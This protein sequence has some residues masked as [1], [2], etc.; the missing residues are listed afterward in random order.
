MVRVLSIGSDLDYADH[1]D[2]DEPANVR[3]YDI[4]F[5]NLRDLESRKDEFLH[6]RV[7]A[8]Y[9]RQ[10]EFPDPEHIVQQLV[11]GGDIFILL[12]YALQAQPS[13]DQDWAPPE[14]IPDDTPIPGGTPVLNFLSWLPFELEVHDDGGESVAE[15]TIDEDWGWYFPDEFSWNY[16]IPKQGARVDHVAFKVEPLVENRYGECLGARI[17]VNR[18]RGPRSVGLEP[19]WGTIYLLP[20]MDGWGIEHLAYNVMEYLYPDVDIETVGRQPD[21]LATYD[22]PR[23]RELEQSIN[24]LEEELA[25][26]RSVK[27]LLWEED[28]ELQEAVYDAL[29]KAGVSIQEEVDSR[30]DGAIDLG[31]QMVMLE[32]TGTTGGVS[33]RKI[34]QLQKWVT[35]NEKGYGED[36]GG[37]LVYN[38]DR[39]NDPAD[40]NLN[41]DPE[42][43]G[44]LEESGLQLVT[45]LELFKMVLGIEAGDVEEIDVEE[46][47]RSDES[48][49]RFDSVEDPF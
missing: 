14:P 22:G 39:H 12:P 44:Y 29:R 33:E 32:I 19:S 18:S 9:Q 34:S 31:D 15:D 30:Q 47:L 28:D 49:I 4:A 41:L 5:V 43:L 38:F 6:T 13:E 2:W 16:S 11:S 21:W 7:P 36:L 10:Y 46:K 23:E 26:A 27:R 24:D 42:R 45:T 37:L 20:L 25:E 3:D 8:E 1:T 35:T 17:K 48:V 40:R